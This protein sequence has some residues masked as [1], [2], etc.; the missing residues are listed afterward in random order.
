M[1][2][3][4]RTMTIHPS[5]RRYRAY[6]GA[7]MLASIPISIFVD[8]SRSYHEPELLFFL[9][10]L[11]WFPFT[12]PQAY[13]AQHVKSSIFIVSNSGLFIGS[14]GI[15]LRSEPARKFLEVLIS[16]SLIFTALGIL[17]WI[18]DIPSQTR[19][20]IVDTFP[21]ARYL[22]SPFCLA[23]GVVFMCGP[24]LAALIFV[25]SELLRSF[26]SRSK[27]GLESPHDD[28]APKFA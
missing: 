13:L 15:I 1:A 7:A 16:I 23:W 10:Q 22:L 18:P 24:P 5:N 2:V 8:C 11:W 17:W 27:P 25:R 12:K 20:P 28:S 6:L 19:G 26:I 9:P 4:R 14:L 21:P 3:V